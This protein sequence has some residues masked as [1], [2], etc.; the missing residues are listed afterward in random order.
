MTNK[1]PKNTGDADPRF[2]R[3]LFGSLADFNEDRPPGLIVKRTEE[4]TPWAN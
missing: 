2:H 1:L 4:L 3:D